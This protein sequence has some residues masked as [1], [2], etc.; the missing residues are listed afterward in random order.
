MIYIKIFFLIFLVSAVNASEFIIP[1]VPF[2]KSTDNQCGP[3]SL[4]MVLNFLGIKIS[5]SEIS[6]E[7]Y[8]KGAGGTS[9]FDMIFYLKKLG[10][11]AKHYRGT[12]SDL[13]EKIK[14]GN[15]IIVMVDEGYWFYKKYH[16]MVVV[17]FNDSEIIVNSGEKEKE[18]IKLENFMEKWKKTDFWTLYIQEGKNGTS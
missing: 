12:L 5:P 8:S 11:K 14:N 13:K 10:L 4:A 6:K 17:G 1:E 18:R 2:Y 15:P 3:T 9:E 16:Y 7:I